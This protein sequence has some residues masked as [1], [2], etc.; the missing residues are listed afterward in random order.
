MFSGLFSLRAQTLHVQVGM[1]G[2]LGKGEG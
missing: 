1:L 2:L